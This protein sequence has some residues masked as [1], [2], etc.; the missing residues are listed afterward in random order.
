MDK[1]TQKPR[2][3]LLMWAGLALAGISGP[4]WVVAAAAGIEYVAFIIATVVGLVLAAV[5]FGVRV[6]RAV[7]HN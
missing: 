7:E 5:G 4:L 2:G 6:L 3:F 1:A